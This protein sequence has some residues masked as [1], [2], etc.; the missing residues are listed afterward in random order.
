MNGDD[1]LRRITEEVAQALVPLEEAVASPE[2]FSAL[3]RELG[4]DFAGAVPPP[5][6]A[7]GAAIA[8]LRTALDAVLAGTPSLQELEDLR[9]AIRNVVDAVR[10]LANL[11]PGSFPV[12]L[13]A[14]GF[15]DEFPGRL[16]E[17]LV[18]THLQ[19]NHPRLET[20]LRVLG[21]V[22]VELVPAAA[23]RPA[24]VARRLALPDLGDLLSDPSLVLQRVYGW[25]TP[26]FRFREVFEHVADLAAVFG[27]DVY[28]DELDPTLV[29]ALEGN[30]VTPGQPIRWAVKAP[31]LIGEVA[32]APVES[33]IGLFALPA[34][35]THLPGLSLLPYAEGQLQQRVQLSERVA[36]VIEA[37]ADLTAGA[38]VVLRPN[39]PIDVLTDLLPSA[40]A[41]VAP[42][43]GGRVRI[44]LE[45]AAADGAPT[46]LAGAD[47]VGRVEVGSVAL[48][49]Q[50]AADSS[51]GKDLSVE[52][53]LNGAAFVLAP[54][55][56]D[57]FLRS[58]LPAKG[59]SAR[60]D[61]AL[62]LS[63]EH[64]F[65]F[66]GSGA[67]QVSVP[68]HVEVGGIAFEAITVGAVP[69]GGTI[70]LEFGASISAHLGPLTARVDN[71]GLRIAFSFPDSGGNLGPLQVE[72]GFKPPS[73]VGLSIAGGGFKGGGFLRFE[74]EQAR[75][76]GALELQFQ[77][78]ITLKAIGLLTTRMPDGGD[79]FSL[80]IVITSEFKPIQLGFGF[81]L[82]AVGGLLGLN[83]TVNTDRLVSGLRDN[84]LRSILFPTDIIANADRIISDLGQVFP[85][86]RGRFLF[87][88]M[89]KITWGTPALLTADLGLVIEVPEPVRLIILGVIRGILPDDSAAILR[90]Q[91][92]FFGVIDFEKEQFS[93]DAAL[94]DSKLLAFTLTGD[95]ALRLYWGAD[96]NFLQTVGG[97]HPA[98]Q[99]P[100]MNLP[101]LRRLTVAL[102][103]GDNPRLTLENYFAITSNSVQFGARVE[104]YAAAWKFN[105][106]G[107]LSYDALFQFNPFYFIADVTAM[108][109]LRVGSS[110]I[111]SIKLSFTL[112][113]PTPWKAKGDAR[114]KLCW[115]F[116][117]KVRFNKTFGEARNTLLPDLAVLPLLLEAL[118][119][120]GNWEEEIPDQ[121]HRLESLRDVGTSQPDQ[122]FVH[123]VGTLKISQKVA[124]LNVE[125]DRIGSQRPADA[126]E[127][128]ISDVR[129]GANAVSAAAA[130]ESFAPAQFFDLG[131]EEKLGSPSFKSFDSGVRVGEPDRI[132]TAYAAAREVKYELKIIDSQR[133]QRLSPPGGGLVDIDPLAFNT[134][135][136]QGTIAKSELS[137][138]RARKSALAPEEVGVVEEAFAIVHAGNLTLFD[139]GSVLR[140]ERAALKQ[141]D[142]LIAANPALRGSLQVVPLFEVAA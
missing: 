95:M 126:R 30:A 97:F 35:G 11:P 118:S 121:R 37:S 86:E 55:K 10:A 78:S 106:Y 2:R 8:D 72:P 62:G 136:L 133:D 58:L 24:H 56:A 93:F 111:A 25:G 122:A 6:A 138:A 82:N 9:T 127:F 5:I 102:L 115:F 128:R 4:W 28:L 141:R 44:R 88:P 23:N 76:S 110:I 124:P 31:L 60:F 108:L 117:L 81:N 123:P 50:A 94:F 3:L 34:A 7:L 19:H 101:A 79:G 116:T 109:A 52:L 45:V 132:H 114:L 75:Y 71:V 73:G 69:A 54:D 46:V 18:V 129:L 67:L 120:P 89:A 130:Q 13:E 80:L 17:L 57:N 43:T 20:P 92:N 12:E 48:T 135:T 1:T 83:R 142:A 131:D 33:G 59:T 87:G 134:W 66:R 53:D 42:P 38:G 68:V 139:G 51:G 61:L 15:V 36:L 47:G 64:G 22:R 74:P 63:A 29:L 98:Y 40:T 140:G 26:D 65:Y 32:G 39:E 21:I 41:G 49:G 103:D 99:P 77:D 104:L 107:F 100:P 119:A 14:A 105:V 113:G 16:V 84:T 27:V 91:V 70:P 125:I 96:A 137:F 112:E 85:P 90:L